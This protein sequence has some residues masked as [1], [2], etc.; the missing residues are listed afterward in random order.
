[1]RISIVGAGY[2]G[3]VTGACL[4]EFGNHVVCLDL[5]EVK[6]ATLKAGRIPIHEPGLDELVRSNVASGR[7]VFTSNPAESV[8]HGLVQM[9]AVGTPSDEDGSSD[10]RYVLRAARDI[11]RLMTGER[12]VVV[13]STVPVGTCD[14]VRATVAGEL[15][16][17]GLSGPF[18]VV[19]NPE[20]LKEGSAVAD[21]M[22][23]DRV[24]VGSEDDN[25]TRVLRNLYAPLQRNHERFFVMRV[26]SAELAKYAANAMLAT[27]IS[28]MNELANLAERVG[29]DIDQVRYSIGSD[30]RI[31]HDFL[32]A[33]CGYGGSCFPKDVRALNRTALEHGMQLKIT[34]AVDSVNEQQKRML[35]LKILARFDNQVS[36]LRF[37]LWGLAFK[38]GTN[39]MREAPSRVIIDALAERGARICAHDPA[40]MDEA[41]GIYRGS[42]AVEFAESPK[43]ALTCA[44]ALII[45]TDWRVFKSPDFDEIKRLL[46]QPVVFD[47][48]NLFEPSWVVSHGLEY[49]AIGRAAAA[50]EPVTLTEIPALAAA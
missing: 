25:A 41:R 30:A 22:R 9:I 18:S 4:A 8:A 32:Y 39:D 6:I 36:G 1:M 20:F 50:A 23:P 35:L 33:G 24:L 21:F 27:R 3:L 43:A 12:I 37:A 38:A 17:R 13:K 28:F 16:K 44:D 10:I 31:G 40:A 42:D 49:Y 45:V 47:G 14:L 26:R 2:V 46:R 19:S 34:T 11:G 29:A 7:L 15:R 5:D 48:R